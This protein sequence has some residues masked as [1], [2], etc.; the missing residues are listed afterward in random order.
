MAEL[1]HHGGRLRAA[2]AEYGIPITHWLDLSTGINPRG[3]PV[4]SLPAHI[5]Q[6]LPED[7]D[8][9]LNIAGAY[10]GSTHLLPCAGSQQAIQ[11]LPGLRP[12]CRVGM[13]SPCYAEHPHAWRQA[14]HHVVHVPSERIEAQLDQLDVLLLVHPNNPTGERF[15]P[16]QLLAW[17]ARLAARG[18]W[19]VIDEA[20]IDASPEHS[21]SVHGGTEGLVVLRSLG[22]FFGLAGVRAGFVLAWPSLLQRLQVVFGP[23]AVSHPAREVTRLALADSEW[24]SAARKELA[25]RGARL[26]ALL[27]GSGLQPLGGTALFQYVVTAQAAALHEQLARQG[28]LVRLFHQPAALRFGLPATEAEWQRLT[29]TLQELEF[30]CEVA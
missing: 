7:D 26:S 13:L 11:A 5:W 12:P 4:P 27:S 14:G 19:L 8:G 10:Y 24:Q 28:I 9:L 29:R 22:K 2:A 16:A 6:R 21:L 18:G 17:H 20:F 15:T 1:L 23:W 3:W 25:E 30:E